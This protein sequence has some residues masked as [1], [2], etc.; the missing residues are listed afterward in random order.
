[1]PLNKKPLW[2]TCPPT[3]YHCCLL[4]SPS[5][6]GHQTVLRSHTLP[7]VNIIYFMTKIDI[8]SKEDL[9]RCLTFLPS[10]Y[11]A[12][13]PAQPIMTLPRRLIQEWMERGCCLN[14]KTYGKSILSVIE[15]WRSRVMGFCWTKIHAEIIIKFIN[16]AL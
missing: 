3:I 12:T 10:K 9:N 7:T 6:Q 15:V 14:T 8:V 11:G 16:T 13:T 1:M 4:S 2:M 5:C